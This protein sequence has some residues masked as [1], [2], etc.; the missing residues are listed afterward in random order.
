MQ[1]QRFYSPNHSPSYSSSSFHGKED[2]H[3]EKDNNSFLFDHLFRDYDLVDAF[4]F[5]QAEDQPPPYASDIQQALLLRG[6]TT[7]HPPPPPHRLQSSPCFESML[8][9]SCSTLYDE[10]EWRKATSILGTD[11]DWFPYEHPSQL[12]GAC[13]PTSTE[14]DD[15]CRPSNNDAEPS[16]GDNHPSDDS[17]SWDSLETKTTPEKQRCPPTG[18]FG[19]SRGPPPPQ[20]QEA[21][22]TTEK[23]TNQPNA[24]LMD[25]SM[26][27]FSSRPD[28]K[29]PRHPSHFQQRAM[30]PSPLK[31]NT[32]TSGVVGNKSSTRE[33]VEDDHWMEHG[34]VTLETCKE[35]HASFQPWVV[36]PV[37]A[38]VTH[39]AL[40]SSRNQ[41]SWFLSNHHTNNN[42]SPFRISPTTL[43]SATPRDET[44]D[45]LLFPCRKPQQP[46]EEEEPIQDKQETE[47]YCPRCGN[48]IENLQHDQRLQRLE[49]E[50][51]SLFSKVYKL[52]NSLLSALKQSSSFS[53]SNNNNSNNNNDGGEQPPPLPLPRILP[54]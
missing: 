25:E 50:Y 42:T 52:Q 19:A 33:E 36:S 8:G 47:G 45:F 12:F 40:S 44:D 31:I 10:D 38:P 7:N 43:P 21:A 28:E 13:L 35:Y 22:A 26:R 46:Q 53:Y 17:E 9:P 14:K 32:A 37:P 20:Q 23:T 54:E 49:N 1:P 4:G 15:Y 16:N 51:Q 39:P 3:A 27:F 48:V 29:R 2:D 30:R 24:M 41:P 5:V 6:C 34:S 11:G 18:Y